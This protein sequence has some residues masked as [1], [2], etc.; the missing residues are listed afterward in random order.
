MPEIRVGPAGWSYEDWRGKVYP[1]PEPPGFDALAFLSRIFGSIEIN[2]TFYRPPPPRMSESWANRTPPGFVFTVKAWE[3]FTHTK[4]P[5]RPDETRAFQEGLEP[6]LAAG[7][8]GAI[9]LQFPWFFRDG[10]DAR[11]RIRRAAEALREWAP[12]VIE[13]RHKSWLGAL[14]F[15]REERLSFCNIDQPESS[16]S[17]TRTRLVTGPVGYIRLHGRNAKAWFRKE[18]GRDEK[19][20]YLYSLDELREWVEAVSGM[21]AERIFFITNNHF[22]GKA[23]V[24]A[25]QLKRA[26]GEEPVIPEPLKSQYADALEGR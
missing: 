11:D 14:D 19:Y 23:V 25:L 7:K 24:N 20:D 10:P 17:I 18:A 8:L 2:S 4:E 6:L 16:T 3:R 21:E 1:D 13:L 9:L 12:L 15:L 26:L 5:F 22:Q